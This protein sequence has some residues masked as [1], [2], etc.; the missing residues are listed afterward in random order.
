PK[1][2]SPETVTTKP[3]LVRTVRA[4][5]E[6]NQVSGIAGDLMA[7]AERP[8]STPFL[9][10][11]TCPTHIIVGE[12]DQATPPSEAKLMADRIR[13]SRLT[14]IPNAAHLANL[15]QPEAFNRIMQDFA[16]DLA[17]EPAG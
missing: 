3:D 12:L 7:M 13:G 4:M 15:E 11:I 10:E 9:E 8:D 16:S 6:G 5:I 1:L 14:L 17:R 2:L